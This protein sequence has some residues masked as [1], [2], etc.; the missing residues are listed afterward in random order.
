MSKSERVFNEV[1]SVP[2]DPRSDEYKI[3][4][5]AILI[6]KLDG[7]ERRRCPYELGTCQAD[8]WFAGTDE[9]H[10]IVSVYSDNEV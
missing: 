6:L 1:F 4:V 10:A 5:M 9:G 2:R 3:G 8:A 7:G